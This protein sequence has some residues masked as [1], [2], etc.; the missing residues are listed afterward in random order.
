MTNV[1]QVRLSLSYHR[2]FL[3]PICSR[4]NMLNM[5]QPL[6]RGQLRLPWNCPRIRQEVVAKMEAKV[7]EAEAFKIL[8]KDKNLRAV[9]AV[10]WNSRERCRMMQNDSNDGT[11][12]YKT[13]QDSH[14][15][16]ADSVRAS[17]CSHCRHCNKSYK[18]SSPSSRTRRCELVSWAELE[19]I[20]KGGLFDAFG[21]LR[22]VRM[23]T[24]VHYVII[25][26]TCHN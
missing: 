5:L 11:R 25:V 2:G 13:L 6:Q 4:C 10:M 15:R 17:Y 14:E 24:T 9:R 23:Y 16:D 1:E 18:A 3:Q 12:L 26:A 20:S 8:Q 22:Y 7:E 19:R 21:I